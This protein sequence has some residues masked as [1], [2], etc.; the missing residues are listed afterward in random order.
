MTRGWKECATPYN[1]RLTDSREN[2]G[3]DN[4]RDK[5]TRLT[6]PSSKQTRLTLHPFKQT[7]LALP[8]VLPNHRVKKTSQEKNR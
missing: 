4:C 3:S 8:V 2:T 7:R 5:Q 6:L 1:R